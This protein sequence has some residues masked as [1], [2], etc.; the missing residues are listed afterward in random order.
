MERSKGYDG[1]GILL[2]LLGG[3]FLLQNFGF[4]GGLGAFIWAVL[5]GFG[6]LAFLVVFLA[7]RE[8]W[9]ASDPRLHVARAG[10][11]H[12]PGRAGHRGRG[13]GRVLPCLH[14]LRVSRHLPHPARTLVGHHP[15][16]R[17]AD[18]G[19]HRDPVLHLAW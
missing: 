11:D 19:R 8:N 9:W 14:R 17:A 16:G 15:G 7:N 10:R 18:A 5:F 3:L 6:G 4:L 12:G 13:D 1:L 2:V